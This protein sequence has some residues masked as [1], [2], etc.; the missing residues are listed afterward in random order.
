MAITFTQL[1]TELDEAK[2]AISAGNWA[3]ARSALLRANITLLGLPLQAQKDGTMVMYRTIMADIEKQITAAEA[4]ANSSGTG[5]NR[6]IAL[7]TRF[8]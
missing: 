8:L 7:G 5:R 2:T 4:S 1:N 3:T 6:C